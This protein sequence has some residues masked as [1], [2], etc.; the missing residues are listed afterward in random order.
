[1]VGSD[2]CLQNLQK[3]DLH[4]FLERSNNDKFIVTISIIPKKKSVTTIVYM[5]INISKWLQL[6]EFK[7]LTLFFLLPFLF[8]DYCSSHCMA[9]SFIR[10]DGIFEQLNSERKIAYLYH[11][12]IF[13]ISQHLFANQSFKYAVANDFWVAEN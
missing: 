5:R 1:M 9:S 10:Y 6:S 13:S 11:I 7:E 2:F 3:I 8:I 12:R 4:T